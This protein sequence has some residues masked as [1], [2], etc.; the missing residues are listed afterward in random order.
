MT[1]PQG[2]I[3]RGDES[4]E[5]LYNLVKRPDI[6]TIVDIGTWH[7]MGS[8]KCIID[9]I[10]DSHKK[11]CNVF[12]LEIDKLCYEKAKI[13][14]GFLASNIHL[15]HGSIFTGNELDYM[16][17][18]IKPGFGSEDV[19]LELAS[20][21][22]ERDILQIKKATNV[23]HLLPEKIDLLVID[24]GEFAGEAEFNLLKNRT[25]YFYLDDISSW[26]NKKNANYVLAN[27]KIF[28]V[29]YTNINQT[30]ICKKI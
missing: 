9:G 29:I 21:W 30:L 27:P 10:L 8:T 28:E 18:K 4:A 11:D 15:I 22:L 25:T 1:L 6:Y 19:S 12:S 14:L 16:R 26:K 5:Q 23:L 20:K 7:G 17:E 24:G 3:R 13:N 2:M